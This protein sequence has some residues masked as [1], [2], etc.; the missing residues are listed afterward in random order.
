MIL[1]F[2]GTGNSRYAANLIAGVTGDELISINNI[3]RERIESPYTARYAF[4]SET[5]F[6]VVCPTYCGRSPKVVDDF[7]RDSRFVGSNEMYFHLTCGGATGEAEKYAEALCKEL[8]MKFRGLGS[9]VMPD[10][11][12]IL[13]APSSYDEAHGMLRASVSQIES[14]A[15]LIKS[16]RTLHNNNAGYAFMSKIAPMMY[17]YFISDKKFRVT[18]ACIGCGKCEELCPL[19]NI[20]LVDSKPKWNGNCTHCVAC[21]SACPVN[22]IE[23]G[24][25]TEKRRRYYL[26]DDGTQKT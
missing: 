17:K 6:V 7:L 10:N 12:L 21:I 18:D 15:R 3:M 13:Y 11:Y 4:E 25:L 22:A 20:T 26:N 19:A 16:G 8:G 24:K 14:N 2:T 23:Y 9:S 1:Y 5:P